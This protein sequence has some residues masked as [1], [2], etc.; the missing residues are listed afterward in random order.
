MSLSC[1]HFKENEHYGKVNGVKPLPQFFAV[2]PATRLQWAMRRPPVDPRITYST[3]IIHMKPKIPNDNVRPKHPKYWIE[4][5]TYSFRRPTSSDTPHIQQ[6]QR[7]QL[8]SIHN[9]PSR[10][11]RLPVSL[12]RHPSKSIRF[13][14]C[15][16]I[17]LHLVTSATHCAPRMR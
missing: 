6:C 12:S 9:S 5:G 8:N 10:A 17:Y 15:S 14:H 1:S 13:P 3:R 11:Q 2:L 4:I 7:R 16:Q